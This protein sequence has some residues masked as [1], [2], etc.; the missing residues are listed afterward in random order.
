VT[1]RVADTGE[2][3]S[4]ST[5]IQAP[6]GQDAEKETGICVLDL[7]AADALAARIVGEVG[8]LTAA[9]FP[10]VRDYAIAQLRV[11]RLAEYL[12]HH[13]DFDAR[14]RPRPALELLRRWLERAE[15]ARSRVGL[16]PVSR[17]ALDVDRTLVAER[18]R[19]W[20]RADLS[21]GERLRREAE[22]RGAIRMGEEEK[23]S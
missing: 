14:G 11:W 2:Q 16:D 18:V 3:R 19:D 4:A 17:A 13:G 5:E 1:A 23:R 9:D 8:H 7:P 10:A 6:A 22:Q 21:E 12:E 15:R 20:A